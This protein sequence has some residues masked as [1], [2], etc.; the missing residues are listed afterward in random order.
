MSS[1]TQDV[2]QSHAL[3]DV[4]SPLLDENGGVKST[5][6]HLLLDADSGVNA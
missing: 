3:L 6:P 4:V 1:A 5:S 2:G